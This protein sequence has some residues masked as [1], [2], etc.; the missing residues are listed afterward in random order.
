MEKEEQIIISLL[1]QGDEKA[2]RYVYDHHY[3][4]LCK[5]ANDF[6]GNPFWAESIV[7]DAIFHLWE[8]RETLNIQTSLRAYL[9]RTVRNRCL[10]HL[11]LEHEKHETR[12][13]DLPLETLDA[14]LFQ[15]KNEQC[16]LGTLLEKELEEKIIKAMEAIPTEA[17]RIFHMS[18]FEHKKNEEIATELGVSVNTIKYYL[19][20]ALAVLRKELGNYWLI[21]WLL[22]LF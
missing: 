4:I 1:K 9:M 13:S 5:M 6:L 8:I 18:R 3:T 14:A 22:N 16:P 17:Y 11:E 15:Q 12:F 10:N 19:K 7:E 20:K 2:Y 21:L